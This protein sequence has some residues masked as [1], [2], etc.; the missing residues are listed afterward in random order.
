M[1]R[2]LGAPGFAHFYVLRAPDELA[3]LPMQKSSARLHEANSQFGRPYG[4]AIGRP[5][6]P[7]ILNKNKKSWN[8][9]TYPMVC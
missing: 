6:S 4:I 2:L 3:Y 5:Q 9:T 8:K 7:K 1:L